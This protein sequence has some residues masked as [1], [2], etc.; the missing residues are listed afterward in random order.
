MCR[1]DKKFSRVGKVP[2]QNS[3][4]KTPKREYRM[5]VRWSALAKDYI[6]D[7]I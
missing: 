4:Q 5:V 3:T 7:L 2:N 6:N 1:I